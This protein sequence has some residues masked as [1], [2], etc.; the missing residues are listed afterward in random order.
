MSKHESFYLTKFSADPNKQIRPAV[1]EQYKDVLSYNLTAQKADKKLQEHKL[2]GLKVSSSRST[3]VKESPIPTKMKMRKDLSETK[4]VY[5]NQLTEGELNFEYGQGSAIPQHLQFKKNYTIMNYNT[6][7]KKNKRAQRIK[8]EDCDKLKADGQSNL[9][10][11]K[12]LYSLTVNNEK[13]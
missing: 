5:T 7:V 3:L 13:S 9:K 4:P 2:R 11:R 6:E 8:R 1:R 12:K 10:S